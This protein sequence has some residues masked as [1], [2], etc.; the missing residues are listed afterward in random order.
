VSTKRAG[1]WDR[2]GGDA[3]GGAFARRE[4]RV[5]RGALLSAADCAISLIAHP[6][7]AE[8][9]YRLY[10]NGSLESRSMK[11]SF[12][13]GPIGPSSTARNPLPQEA[14]GPTMSLPRSPR[15]RCASGSTPF[16]AAVLLDLGASPPAALRAAAGDRVLRVPLRPLARGVGGDENS[17]IVPAWERLVGN[18]L[19]A[20][21]R[22]I[23]GTADVATLPPSSQGVDARGL[24]QLSRLDRRER[25]TQ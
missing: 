14:T 21:C 17:L 7:S 9:L 19:P 24:P 20:V 3:L 15:R 11:T 22:G 13:I 16:P 1:A 25:C 6:V 8:S 18:R 10:Q 2:R 23:C 12:A 5:H 4:D